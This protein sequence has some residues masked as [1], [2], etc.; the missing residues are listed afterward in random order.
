MD[1]L[2]LA[3]E[4]FDGMGMYRTSENG[5]AID[6]SAKINAVEVKDAVGLGQALH[7]D[8]AATSCLV[9][10]LVEYGTRRAPRSQDKEW[11]T[12]LREQFASLGY[13]VPEILRTM[14]TSDAFYQLAATTDEPLKGASK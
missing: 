4:N 6:A 12:A 3:L 11:V 8:P 9:N 14:L 1:P 5:S 7:D 13:R 10:R 2:G